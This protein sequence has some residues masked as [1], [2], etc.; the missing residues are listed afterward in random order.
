MMDK[1]P[2]RLAAYARTAV[3]FSVILSC[4]V[5]VGDSY[6]T[7]WYSFDEHEPGW[8]PSSSAAIVMTNTYGTSFSDA[9]PYVT[10]GSSKQATPAEYMPR[11]TTPFQG[12]C[13]YDPL[14]GTRRVNRSALRFTT[15]AEDGG[16]GSYYGGTLRIPR[17]DKGSGSFTMD[18]VTIEC[19]VCTTGGVFD[20]FSPIFGMKNG[21]DWANEAW[22]LYMT[23]DG[24]LCARFKTSTGT[25][26]TK[27]S[28]P[29][30]RGTAINDGNWHHVAMRYDK[31]HGICRVYEDYVETFNFHTTSDDQANDP[32][33]YVSGSE[34]NTSLYIGGY[35][36]CTTSAPLKGRKF[37][38]CIDE[39]R[40]TEA[41]LGPHQ[42][43]RI[44]PEDKDEIF[45]LRLDPH[46][47]YGNDLGTNTNVNY[48]ANYYKRNY[49]YAFD[50]NIF[51]AVY[52]DCGGTASLDSS[53][54]CAPTIKGSILGTNSCN[55]GS[56]SLAT[57]DVGL[58]GYMQV[59]SLTK[60]MAMSA[61]NADAEYVEAETNFDYTV[62]LFFKTRTTEPATGVQTIYQIGSWPV[63]GAVVNRDDT[64][65]V[66]FTWNDG[67][68]MDGE[69][70][71]ANWRGTYS[72][73]TTAND[74]NWH[75]I[76]TVCDTARKQMRFYYDGRLTAVSNN[77]NNTIQTGSS[78]F[79]GS[80]SFGTNSFFDGWIDDIRITLRALSP[81]EFLATNSIVADATMPGTVMITDFEQEKWVGDENQGYM[82]APYMEL[83]RPVSRLKH[84][85]SNKYP[86]MI[87]CGRFYST[88]GES[89]IRGAKCSKLD[90][91]TLAW[92]ECPLYEQDEFTVEF[93]EKIT[94]LEA[95]ASPIR[96]AD[97]EGIN[98]NGVWGL[99]R[100]PTDANRLRLRINL[101]KDGVPSEDDSD[102]Y[103][104]AYWDISPS[105]ADGQ[106][107]HYA[108][109]LATKDGTNTVVELFRDYVSLGSKEIDG[110]IDYTSKASGRLTVGG[111]TT[112]PPDD[113]K[114]F[115]GSVDMLRFS[116]GVL[117]PD[118]FIQYKSAGLIMVSK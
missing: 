21:T 18:N 89:Y 54:S 39:F 109:T 83:T 49:T 34:D 116:K 51:S 82:T 106:W 52:I 99:Y 47:Y 90:D 30:G 24:K 115:Y 26:I 76:A 17:K 79:V 44:E 64:G 42:F 20:T 15:A 55:Y 22:A 32:I 45:R 14:T 102:A 4:E 65:R 112:Y 111:G 68:N 104:T 117:T 50:T 93:F 46:G 36:H 53:E 23:S 92:K 71:K 78:L 5:A 108:F 94:G 98:T 66:C 101:M 27:G 107:H 6:R 74:G 59:K 100:D 2:S 113:L 77:V 12:M 72:T 48:S 114:R 95:E 105:I 97:A 13:I 73:E 84:G 91:A 87:G 41:A 67:Y 25:K 63:A 38:G 86:Q 10:V 110:R 70:K 43:L 9:F 61:F 8:T 37:N 19:F 81:S 40:I 31:I 103:N 75:H 60:F 57:N 80:N 16:T 11:Y 33:S 7:T 28:S 85:E 1:K 88:D 96:Y 118:K 62:E 3:A 58:S 69:E 56:L 35:V 29:Y